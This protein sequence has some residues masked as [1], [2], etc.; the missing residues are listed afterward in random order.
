MLRLLL[1]ATL[2]VAAVRWLPAPLDGGAVAQPSASA[3]PDTVV[4]NDNRKPAGAVESGALRLRLVARL[5]S[6][7]PDLDV[8][9]SVTVMA[10]AEEGSA[11]TIPGP[12]LRTTSG[13]EIRVSVR[14]SIPDSTL[15][16]HGLRA[17]TAGAGTMHV[18]PGETR[19]VTFRAGAPGTYL[20]WGTTTHS[21]I[22]DRPWRDSQLTGAIVIDPLGTPRDTAERI[23]VMTV[24]DVYLGDT[25]RNKA[26]EDIWELAIN[27]RSWPHTE[28]LEYAANDTVR[29]RWVNGGYLPHPMHLH[30]FHFRVLA[31]GDG[32]RDTLYSS[33]TERLAV[34]ELM[35]AGSTFRME[36][37]PT[38]QGSWL[39]H[40]HMIPHITPFPERADSVRGHDIHDVAR[41][42]LV[43]MSGLVLGI[44]IR[45]PA[46]V[47]AAVPLPQRRL[48]VFVQESRGDTASTAR[49]GFVLQRGREPRVD[50]V[51]VPGTPLVLVRGE[52]AA[53]TVI[54]RLREPT[55]VHW[56]GMELESVYDGVAGWSRTGGSIAP[57]LAPGDSFTA[58]MTPPRAGTYMYHTHMDEGRQLGAGLY[59]PL[60]VLE[61]GERYDPAMDLTFMVGG[62]VAGKALAAAINGRPAPAPIELRAG[63]RYRLRLVNI[64]FAPIVRVELAADSLPLTWRA[65][66]KDGAD[67]PIG[68][69]AVGSAHVRLGVGE[70]YDFEWTPERPMNAALT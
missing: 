30:G 12:L 59:G 26:K 19:E 22:A 38:R 49:N 37:V 57:L 14:N 61:P 13:T 51:E 32:V 40:C 44:T 15:V 60:L 28:R 69:R 70:T 29:W 48:R 33:A 41:H 6:W 1:L 24:L 23:F 34:T 43:S 25:V 18:R 11:A 62:A 31:K 16:V 68:K 58:V 35:S 4:P 47:P 45:D 65:L 55:T 20:Y 27:G 21:P 64:L 8:D 50:S 9:T 52:T 10:F 42:P 5:A 2:F 39:M 66:A 53:I 56:H 67:L 36:W 17:G 7:R 3:P 63:T 54:N 46:P